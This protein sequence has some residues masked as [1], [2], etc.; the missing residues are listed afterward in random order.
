MKFCVENVCKSNNFVVFEPIFET[1]FHAFSC[2]ALKRLTFYFLASRVI[3]EGFGAYERQE[4][5]P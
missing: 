3:T 2:N 1:L 4:S 5:T